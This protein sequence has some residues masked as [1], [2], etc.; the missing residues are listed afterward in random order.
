MTLCLI[1]SSKEEIETLYAKLSAGGRMEHPLNE[2]FFIGDLVD[3]FGM[4]WMLSL[5]KVPA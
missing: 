5:D 3:K 4:S 1:C 2:E